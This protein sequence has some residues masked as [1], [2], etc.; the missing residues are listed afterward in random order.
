[1]GPDGCQRTAPASFPHLEELAS[2]GTSAVGERRSGFLHRAW[3]EAETDLA[4]RV[5][6]G[7]WPRRPALVSLYRAL[8]DPGGDLREALQGA[9][10]HPC[11][12]EVAGRRLRVLE[13]AGVIRWQPSGTT[14]ALR[15]VS[16][17]TKDLELIQA[18]VAYR[19]RCEEGR[20]FLSRQ[21]QPN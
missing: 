14:P 7:E 4:L 5:H 17:E 21:R 20:R 12:P 1:M 8:S 16:S 2:A 15:V 18:F 13:E 11:S 10:R 3:G 6:E 9:G 19:D